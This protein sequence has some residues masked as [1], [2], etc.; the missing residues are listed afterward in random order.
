MAFYGLSSENPVSSVLWHLYQS[1]LT[2]F[3]TCVYSCLADN[4]SPV[5]SATR[6]KK[7]D[8]DKLYRRPTFYFFRF[9]VPYSSVSIRYTLQIDRYLAPNGKQVETDRSNG[10]IRTI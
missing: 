10:S 1:I 2:Q 8:A 7:E 3:D 4:L 5:G 6:H 9:L